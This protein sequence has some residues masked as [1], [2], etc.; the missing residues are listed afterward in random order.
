MSAIGIEI[1]PGGAATPGQALKS[2]GLPLTS[3]AIAGLG[4]GDP[5]RDSASQSALASFRSNWQ[6]QLTSLDVDSDSSANSVIGEKQTLTSFALTPSSTLL[7]QTSPA[8]VGRLGFGHGFAVEGAVASDVNKTEKYTTGSRTPAVLHSKT[9]REQTRTPAGGALIKPQ[10]GHHIVSGSAHTPNAGKS[11]A[12]DVKPGKTGDAIPARSSLIVPTLVVEKVDTLNQG[13]LDLP[14]SQHA[15]QSARQS[16]RDEYLAYEIQP[17]GPVSSPT[18]PISRPGDVNLDIQTGSTLPDQPLPHRLNPMLDHGEAQIAA[19]EQ[20]LAHDSTAIQASAQGLAD[21]PMSVRDGDDRGYTPTVIAPQDAKS[22]DLSVVAGGN[23]ADSPASSGFEAKAQLAGAKGGAFFAQSSAPGARAYESV[24]TATKRTDRPDQL[25]L[26]QSTSGQTSLADKKTF[27]SGAKSAVP[28]QSMP[29]TVEMRDIPGQKSAITP[30]PGQSAVLK[31]FSGS[32][33][34]FRPESRLGE[35]NDSLL[36]GEFPG[37]TKPGTGKS[38][39]IQIQTG[40]GSTS[41]EISS[42]TLATHATAATPAVPGSNAFFLERDASSELARNDTANRVGGVPA[43]AQGSSTTHQTFAALDDIDNRAAPNWI[44]AGNRHAEAG[45]EDPALGWIG[46]RADQNGGGVHA[47]L[48][49]ATAEAAQALGSQMDGLNAHLAESHTALA[50]LSLGSMES[51]EGGA[52]FDQG[53]NQGTGQNQA[54]SNSQDAHVNT[55]ES[56]WATPKFA[57][58]AVSAPTELPSLT[59]HEA[60]HISVIA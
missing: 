43:A 2:L 44:H 33:S 35:F 56:I 17:T 37:V 16:V 23:Q 39:K 21:R 45:F 42:A 22:S 27:S 36:T 60:K 59:D 34:E 47:T 8:V 46:V 41:S 29:A 18:N 9:L 3:K 13:Q 55:T 12:N 40:Q 54:E 28:S 50:S 53:F 24:G 58:T 32:D 6:S 7:D 57:S 19:P 38:T 51:R 5:A 1:E 20:A 48:V 26:T 10:S 52:G 4:Q 31:Q 25:G 15:S 11:T 49:P 14:P 30:G